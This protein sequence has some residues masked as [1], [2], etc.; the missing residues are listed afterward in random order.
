MQVSPKITIITVVFNARTLIESTI[1]SV[2]QQTYPS[3][4]YIIIDGASTDG[5]LE[6]VEKYRSKISAVHSEK[7]QGIYDA[8]N[9][10]LSKATGTY[11]LFLNAGD[12]LAEPQTLQQV[13]AREGDADVYY[14][15]TKIIDTHGR[16]VGDRRLKP[17]ARLNWKSLKF[18]MCVSHQSFIPKRSLCEPYDLQ[19][20]I[21]ADIDWVIRVLKKSHRIVFVNQTISKFLE[22]G[23]S[24][25]NR[26]KALQE[27]FRIMAVHYGLLPTVFN[28]LY[29]LLRYPIHKLFR[30]SMS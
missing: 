29:I 21:S 5:T 13:F 11:V 10:G 20:S 6:V 22:G 3:I 30:R 12:L 17:P 25:K 9:K 16:V 8:M 19:Y 4:E 18:G 23:S 7:D 14:G 28:H 24:A 27:R 2:L 1:Q 15:N 26:K